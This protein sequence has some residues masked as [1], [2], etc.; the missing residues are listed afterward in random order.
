MNQSIL[1]LIFSTIFCVSI[2]SVTAAEA[3]AAAPDCSLTALGDTKAYDVS[4]FHGNVIY[5]D[6]WASWCGPC[7]KSFP[8][9]NEL[10]REL[11]DKGLRLIG[12]NLDENPDDA[13]TFL[14]K[15]PANFTIA[16]DLDE[17]CARAFDVKAMPSSYLI[18]RDGVIRHV[19]LGFKSG[20]AK[21][22]R[23]LVEQVLAENPASRQTDHPK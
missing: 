9:M 15:Y 10:H 7:A 2:Q 12:V 14:D 18:G 5:I 16:A 20:E 22:L 21:E 11:K 23:D 6:F 8:F 19:H 17:Q 3:G 1:A 4:R 13:K